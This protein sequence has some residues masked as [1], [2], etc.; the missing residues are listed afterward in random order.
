MDRFVALKVLKPHVLEDEKV[1]ERFRREALYVSRLSHPNTITLFDYGDTDEGFCY[2]AMEFLKG[3]HLG[4]ILTQEG[5]MKPHRV[6]SIA[7]QVCQSLAEA[8][9]IDLI[10]RDLKPANIFLLKRPRGERVKVLDFGLSK[11]LQ[12]LGSSSTDPISPLTQDG[13]VFGT[14]MYM[15]PEQA[16]DNPIGP[17][18]DVYAMGHIIY[19]MITGEA[20][21]AELDH[22]M[23]IMLRQIYDSP[24]TFPPQ[25]QDSPFADVIYD[26]TRK[27]PEDRIEDAGALLERL[28][29]SA[30]RPLMQPE[31]EDAPSDQEKEEKV[32]PVRSG[33]PPEDPARGPRTG[34]LGRHLDTLHS[35]LQE[36]EGHRTMR[37]AILDGLEGSGR[38]D[39][40][41][42]FLDEARNRGVRTV[43]ETDWPEEAADPGY[44][45]MDERFPGPGQHES[46]IFGELDKRRHASFAR[47]GEALRE[48]AREDAVVWSIPD[49]DDASAQTLAFLDWMFRDLRDR[50]APVL[51]L[52]SLDRRRLRERT[53]LHRYTQGI[54]GASGP[55]ADYLTVQP[56]YT[57]PSL[58]E[59]LAI[60]ATGGEDSSG[61]TNELSSDEVTPV[62]NQAVQP[63]QAGDDDRND[64]LRHALAVLALLGDEIPASLKDGVTALRQDVL[65]QQE[66]DE[67]LERAERIGI[68]VREN[69]QLAFRRHT[70]AASLRRLEPPTPLQTPSAPIR[71]AELL[72]DS[73]GADLPRQVLDL[74]VDHFLEGGAP[75]RAAELLQSAITSA[76][77]S[78]K[79]DDAREFLLQLVDLLDSH[80]VEE[81]SA[82]EVRLQL[83]EIQGALEELGSAEDILGDALVEAEQSADT[84]SEARALKLMGDLAMRQNEPRRADGYYR[85]ARLRFRQAGESISAA[86]VTTLLAAAQLSDGRPDEAADVLT[87]A[88]QTIDSDTH[89]VLLARIDARLGEALNRL[90]E[91]DRAAELLE[92]T[93]REFADSRW[94]DEQRSVCFCA[95]TASMGRGD[96]DAAEEFVE[97]GCEFQDYGAGISAQTCALS[98]VDVLAARD[99]LDAAADLLADFTDEAPSGHDY[100]IRPAFYRGDIAL[101]RGDS[102]AVD[103][104]DNVQQRAREVGHTDWY[105]ESL[106][107]RA[108][109]LYQASKP[110]EACESLQ[111]AQ[112]FADHFGASAG[113]IGA[114]ARKLYFQV[115]QLEESPHDKIESC[116]QE[117]ESSDRTD[118]RIIARTTLADVL[119][120]RDAPDEAAEHLLV[121]RREAA[122]TGRFTLLMPLHRRLA[123]CGRDGFTPASRWPG[124][125]LGTLLPPTGG[126]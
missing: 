7:A 24:L 79:L 42:A 75:D 118:A 41:N 100:D 12:G 87:D 113:I 51:I 101:A 111:K 34:S 33:H 115:H 105:L 45:P 28:R 110:E 3:R 80:S 37:L 46:A 64:T 52:A 36:V 44:R 99:D 121:A 53:G 96:L 11:S 85:K 4:S 43:D 66:F 116:L 97:R 84:T 122:R 13:R 54:L 86:G 57:P 91:F 5:P 8:H 48:A 83:G 18:I 103:W 20:R 112:S 71:A 104:F 107:R 89:P 49:L 120:R 35:H 22:S 19:Q 31:D 90:A 93:A 50:P 69:D 40:L 21:Y 82:L 29:S 78:L 65:T 114:R 81:M 60:G 6:W 30:F 1:V 70:Y 16:M 126:G 9:E 92:E 14:P 73:N 2:I 61:P 72:I 106:V 59:L 23:D 10:H 124:T 27:A 56:G 119:M 63:S 94:P 117:A 108:W 26:C 88:R 102:A 17:T 125:A 123:E 76:L 67:A 55:H 58:D 39:I 62:D 95:A 15:A 25:W 47:R 77:E 98:R 74:A 109:A 38:D 68:I 32:V